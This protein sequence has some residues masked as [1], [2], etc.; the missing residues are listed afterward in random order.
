MLPRRGRPSATGFRA[1][2]ESANGVGIMLASLQLV[3]E[4]FALRP[5]NTIAEATGQT[6]H[7]ARGIEISFAVKRTRGRLVRDMARSNRGDQRS[8]SNNLVTVVERS[9]STPRTECVRAPLF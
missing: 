7:R 3:L 9:R 8:P 4:Q 1:I 5:R 2:G 6:L